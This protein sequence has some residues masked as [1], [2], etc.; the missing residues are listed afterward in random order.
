VARL[1]VSVDQLEAFTGALRRLVRIL[2]R[3]A[4]VGAAGAV[5]LLLHALD[6]VTVE[7]AL[8]AALLLA[9]P[10]VVLLFAQG[11]QELADLPARLRRLPGEGQER[12]AELTRLAG[13][14]QTARA[15]GLPLLLWRLRSSVGSVRQLAG[16][17]I[18]LRVFTPWF[19]I[20]TAVSILL[21]GLLALAGLVALVLLL[22]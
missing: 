22:G 16:I 20:A 18:R 6:D 13:Q 11:V 3:I 9:P 19:L 4:F 1:T 10:V 2:R 17:T 8:L 21:C 5:A 7:D 15:R 14:A 12:L